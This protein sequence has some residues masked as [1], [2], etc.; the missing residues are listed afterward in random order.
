MVAVYHPYLG[1]LHEE[2]KPQEL[3]DEPSENLK[4][5]DFLQN[6]KKPLDCKDGWERFEQS[7]KERKK[8]IQKYGFSIYSRETLDILA[9]YLKSQEDPTL[10]IF[11]GS[12]YLSDKLSKRG[13]SIIASDKGAESFQK[14]KIN[15]VYKRDIE[16]DVHAL[17]LQEFSSVIMAWPEMN[18]NAY[19]VAQ[20]MAAGQ[21][22]IYIGED[23]GGCTASEEFFSE[24]N[25]NWEAMTELQNA[26]NTHHYN[27]LSVY[28]RF[29]V[30]R[31]L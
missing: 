20:K 6:S 11:A 14:Y 8:F 1:S 18:T 10:E 29:F 3:L 5:I 4:K 19:L 12:G 16:C 17:N 22:L 28:D 27:F 31:K 30:Y 13:V 2:T 15:N 23:E 26:L 21:V 9:Q 25:T 7:H 24:V